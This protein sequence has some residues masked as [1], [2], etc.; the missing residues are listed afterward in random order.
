VHLKVAAFDPTQ[1]LESLGECRHTGRRFWIIC[2]QEHE[3][4]DPTQT[5]GLL[6]MPDD[7]LC[8]RTAEEREERAP[9]HSIT[10]SARATSE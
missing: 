9:V 4:A 7:G 8:Y 6:C 2:C 5:I 10:S 3:H 1:S